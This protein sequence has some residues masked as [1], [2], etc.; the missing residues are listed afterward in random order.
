MME[1]NVLGRY[2]HYLIITV[3]TCKQEDSWLLLWT[4]NCCDCRNNRLHAKHINKRCI[5]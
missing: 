1:F 2:L 5:L 4:D 3:C